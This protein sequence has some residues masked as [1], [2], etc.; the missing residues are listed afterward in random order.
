MGA[1]WLY[2]KKIKIKITCLHK[3]IG[4]ITLGTLVEQPFLKTVEN[5]ARKRHKGVRSA[6]A[7]VSVHSLAFLPP[8]SAGWII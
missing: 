1:V 2:F 7:R 5:A 6:S 3:I 4:R 8:G